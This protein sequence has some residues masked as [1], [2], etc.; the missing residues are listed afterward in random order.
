MTPNAFIG[1]TKA[2]T[3]PDLAAALG[4]AKPLWDLVVVDMAQE[5]SLADREWK[6]YGPKYGWA[7]RLKRGKRNIVHLAPCQ[8][9]FTVL[10]ILGDRAVS[11]ARASRLSRVA[12]KLFDEA[13][14]YPEGTGIRFQAKRSK[15]IP[16]IK[17]LAKIKLEN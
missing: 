4:P 8:G 11:A 16:L 5:L 12:T 9:C 13:P 15:D 3:E 7:L 1:R 17:K 2:P 14:R 6:S 10:F